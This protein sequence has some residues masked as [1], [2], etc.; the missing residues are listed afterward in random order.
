M[1][2][3]VSILGLLAVA[4]LSLPAGPA[5]EFTFR[6][7]GAVDL[8]SSGTEAGYG[9]APELVNGKPELVI[10]LGATTGQGAL[11]LFTVG[12]ALPRTG[13]Y[14][15]YFEWDPAGAAGQGRWFH[16]CFVA[17]TTE[18]PMGFFH[19]QAGWVRIT[20]VDAGRISGEFEVRARG[21]LA[22]DT[23][24]ENQWVTVRGTFTAEGDSTVIALGA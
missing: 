10:S 1:Y 12:D 23:T 19:G 21:F 4:G 13:R 6:S 22:A 15:I 11:L 17:G 7:T 20:A 9:L 2:A 5:P 14:P 8:S 24:D 3:R 16:A 18:R